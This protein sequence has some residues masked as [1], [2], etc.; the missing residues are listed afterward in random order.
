MENKRKK[1]MVSTQYVTMLLA[2][3]AISLVS[4]MP[5]IAGLTGFL[6]LDEYLWLNRSRNFTIALMRSDWVET[7]QTGH[8]G[9]TTMWTGSLGLWLYGLR[10]QLFDQ[11]GYLPFLQS[12]SWSHQPQELMLYM[13]LPTVIIV[14]T[15]ILVKL[16]TSRSVL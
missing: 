7:M 9:V 10:H 5:R 12:L 16:Q 11:H 14:T 6:V 4:L 1:Q 3:I 8:P 2:T 15:G 13:R